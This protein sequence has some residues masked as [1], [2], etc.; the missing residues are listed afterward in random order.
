MR[1]HTAGP[2]TVCEHSWSRTGIYS[3]K[4]PIAALDIYDDATE[5]TQGEWEAVMAAN[6][7][8]ISAAPDLLRELEHLVRLLEPAISDG[9]VSVPGLATLN[10][11]RAA[12]AKAEGKS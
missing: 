8:L 10:A 12:I 2:W 9:R 6:A 11:A 3:A 5:E 7:R 4:H 1:K